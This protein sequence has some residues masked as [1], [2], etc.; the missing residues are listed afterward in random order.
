MSAPI[1]E[2]AVARGHATA[3]AAR[4]LGIREIRELIAGIEERADPL[5]LVVKLPAAR[6]ALARLERAEARDQELSP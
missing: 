3:R 6:H 5:D 1:D 4:Q 2:A